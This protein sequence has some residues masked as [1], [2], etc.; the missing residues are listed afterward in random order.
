L[1]DEILISPLRP[2]NVQKIFQFTEFLIKE[3]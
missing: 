3:V 1:E 2:G